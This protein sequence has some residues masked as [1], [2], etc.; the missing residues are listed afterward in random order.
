MAK[1]SLK[2]NLRC[3]KPHHFLFH[4]VQLVKLLANITGVKFS[5]YKRESRTFHVA[6]VQCRQRKL[7][8][9]IFLS[10]RRCRCRLR[11]V[12]SPLSTFSRS[13]S[14]GITIERLHSV[15]IRNASVVEGIKHCFC[16]V[17]NFDSAEIKVIDS[18]CYKSR[19]DKV[20]YGQVI[21]PVFLSVTFGD[22]FN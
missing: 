3:F 19:K 20:S 16:Q 10:S 12:L 2:V 6:V 7:N 22:L 13:F 4:C 9:L 14:L 21:V 15:F 11:C 18:L 1:T 17:L 8:L 5:T